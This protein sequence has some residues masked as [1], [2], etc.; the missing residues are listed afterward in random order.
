MCP[1]RCSARERDLGAHDLEAAV[2]S[3][4]ADVEDLKSRIEDA[5]GK[6]GFRDHGNSN[7]ALHEPSTNLT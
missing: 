5:R 7:S 2:G 6:T 4:L 1:K 3:L